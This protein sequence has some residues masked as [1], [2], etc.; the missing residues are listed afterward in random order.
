MQEQNAVS[1]E[2]FKDPARFADLVNSVVFSGEEVVSPGDVKELDPVLWNVHRSGASLQA[3]VQVQ[4]LLRQV[5]MGFQVIL[6]ALENQTKVHYAM[7]VRVMNADAAKY[8]DQ[9]RK[10]GQ[11][12]EKKKD[13]SG[14]EYLSRFGKE[15]KLL[16]VISIVVYFG[17][18]PWDGPRTLKE[19][20]DLSGC[21]KQMQDL[22]V[23]YPICLVEARK[24]EHLEWFRTDL[25]YVFGFLARAEEKHD[26]RTYVEEH[27]EAFS[28]MRRDAYDLVSVMANMR[29]LE[30]IRDQEEREGGYDMCKAIYDMIEDGRSEGRSEGLAVGREQ[31]ENRINALIARLFEDD[32]AGEIRHMANDRDYQRRL[33]EEYGL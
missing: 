6:V 14:K 18:E 22:I 10:I 1:M 15:D 26:L 19:M 27:R 2:Y 23:D 13:L 11:E 8:H 5:S 20:M 30:L 24:Q 7:P 32:R 21:P 9:C 28:E 4:D 29:E 3:K 31:G 16:P 33:L 17:K 25:R 12:H